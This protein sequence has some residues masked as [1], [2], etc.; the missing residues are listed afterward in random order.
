MLSKWFS[1]QPLGYRFALSF[2][3]CCC[4]SSARLGRSCTYASF[5][6]SKKRF[7]SRVGRCARNAGNRINPVEAPCAVPAN[8]DFVDADPL[9]DT[10]DEIRFGDIEARL[11]LRSFLSNNGTLVGIELLLELYRKDERE[12]GLGEPVTASSQPTRYYYF[13]LFF[14]AE[15]WF[16]VFG[17]ACC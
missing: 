2:C 9:C 10:G 5:R 8:G 1:Q 16:F 6:A 15:C 11:R 17:A 12:S 14:D 3:C 13:Y 7:V 4:C